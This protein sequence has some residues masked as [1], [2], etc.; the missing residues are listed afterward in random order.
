MLN[1]TEKIQL[2]AE[3]FD[4]NNMIIVLKEA[5]DFN[6]SQFELTKKLFKQHLITS[7]KELAKE[8]IEEFRIGIEKIGEEIEHDEECKCG[9][10]QRTTEVNEICE[11]LKKQL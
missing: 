9:L 8:I 7:Q 10:C 2:S 5:V 6:N 11:R 3:E 4:K 1:I